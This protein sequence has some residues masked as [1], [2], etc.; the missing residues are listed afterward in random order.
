[1]TPEMIEQLKVIAVKEQALAEIIAWL[2]GRGLWEECN[3]ELG[4]VKP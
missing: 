2:K 4:I 3:R 1:M